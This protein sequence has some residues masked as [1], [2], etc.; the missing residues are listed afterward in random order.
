MERNYYMELNKKM[1]AG[2]VINSKLQKKYS[3]NLFWLSRRQWS[4]IID[5]VEN[6]ITDVLVVTT[7]GI[8]PFVGLFLAWFG[9]CL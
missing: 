8:L 2:T 7:F 3:T 4:D 9:R 5:R 1:T 6:A